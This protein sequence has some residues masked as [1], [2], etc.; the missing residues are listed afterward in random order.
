MHLQVRSLQVGGIVLRFNRCGKHR[1][2]AEELGENESAFRDTDDDP[3]SIHG[4]RPMTK[5]ATTTC[6]PT[7]MPTCMRIKNQ[8]LARK[9]E[10]S[11]SRSLPVLQLSLPLSKR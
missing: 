7:C 9:P 10:I 11:A 2:N 1:E 6:L 3:I 8:D 5:A 4:P